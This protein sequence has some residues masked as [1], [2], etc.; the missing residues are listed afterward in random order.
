MVKIFGFIKKN[1]ENVQS[2]NEKAISFMMG[3]NSLIKSS[4]RNNLWTV[5][6][7]RLLAPKYL[8]HTPKKSF[9]YNIFS[10]ILSI[11]HCYRVVSG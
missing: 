10:V 6:I 11:F 8:R 1:S 7:S 4:S 5:Y 3:Q 2:F 9:Y